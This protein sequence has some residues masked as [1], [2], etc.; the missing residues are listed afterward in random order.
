[1]VGIGINKTRSYL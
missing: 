1:M